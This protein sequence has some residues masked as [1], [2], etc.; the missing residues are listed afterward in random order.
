MNFN[1]FKMKKKINTNAVYSAR[2]ALEFFPNIGN[3]PAMR[4]FIEDD[5]AGKNILDAKVIMRGTQR[6]FFIKGSKLLELINKQK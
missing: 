3:E 4:K 2:E 1:F 6:R 5:I